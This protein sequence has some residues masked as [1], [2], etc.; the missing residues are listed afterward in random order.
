MNSSVKLFTKL[1]ANRLQHFITRLVHKNQYGFIKSRTIQDCLAWTF[2]YLHH[3]HTSKKEIILKLDFEKKFDKIEH[4]A[5]LSIMAARG[6]GDR[7]IKWMKLIFGSGTSAVLLNGTPGKV[8]H[9]RRGVRQ[10]D[11][12][13]PLLFVLAAD[14]LQSVINRAKDLGMLKLPIPLNFTSDFLIIQYADDTLITMEG[15]VMQLFILKALLNSFASSTGLKV[16]YAKSM[17]VPINISQEKTFVLA[18]TFG[19]SI[20]SLPFTY[21]G[22]PLGTTMPRVDDFLPLVTRC[23]RRLVSTSLFLTQARKLQMTNA[24][25]T[26]LPTFFM[27]S[28]YL[29]VSVREQIDKYRKHCLWRGSDDNNRVNAKAAWTMVTKAKDEG[30]L[31]VLDLKT[32]NEALL[33]KHLHKFF[34]KADIPWCT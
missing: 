22:L 28:F 12:L 6:F 15:N 7:W 30:G 21:L 34:S 18:K 20:G 10:R 16:N 2:E 4:E 17:L 3:C 5:M 29:H 8:L 26:S 14:L 23:E 19:C 24:V 1:L 33:L 31:G 25:F 13:S 9:C 32:Q 27:G 11:P